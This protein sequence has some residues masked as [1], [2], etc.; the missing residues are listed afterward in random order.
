MLHCSPH[1]KQTNVAALLE[2]TIENTFARKIESAK[3]GTNPSNL[4]ASIVQCSCYVQRFPIFHSGLECILR[5]LSIKR[6]NPMHD[7]FK[8]VLL[9][10]T[11]VLL[12]R[13]EVMYCCSRK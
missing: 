10:D 8:I 2:E 11:D 6:L 12:L 5:H 3:M 7:V 4:N 1:D 13:S 9:E